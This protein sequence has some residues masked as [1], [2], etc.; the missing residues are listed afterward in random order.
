MHR[1]IL[2][3]GSTSTSTTTDEIRIPQVTTYG[4]DLVEAAHLAESEN[5]GDWYRDP[6]GWPELR[7]AFIET[8]DVADVSISITSSGLDWSIEPHFHSFEVPKSFVGQ[9]PA[10][11][12]DPMS[13]LTY[14][15]AALRAAKQL[16]NELPE[17]S[18]GW[19]FRSGTIVKNTSEWQKYRD[20]QADLRDASYSGET[21]ITSFFASINV[22]RLIDLLIKRGVSGLPL[23]II[24][25]VLHRHDGMAYR[26]GLPQRSSASALLAQLSFSTIDTAVQE[27]LLQGKIAVARR[28]MDDIGFEGSYE[29]V[30][31]LILRIQAEAR[32]GGLEINA[33]K[34]SI[35]TGADKADRFDREAQRLI[36]IEEHEYEND[37]YPG[38]SFTV[39]SR[40]ELLESQ[41]RVVEQPT[42]ASRTEI[43][44]VLRS[45]RHHQE[46]A[47]VERWMQ[48]AKYIPHGADHLSRYLR[49]AGDRAAI[50]ST[51]LNDWFASE[52]D[53]KWPYA[54]WVAAQHAIAIAGD[55]MS[56]SSLQVLKAWVDD[57]NNVQ[58]LAVAV[59]RLT[60][61][62]PRRARE[63]LMRRIDKTHDP[64][65]LRLL[66]FGLLSAGAEV[67][68]VRPHVERSPHLSL[69]KKYLEDRKWTVSSVVDDFAG[70][71]A[72]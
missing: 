30:Y 72:D 21:D 38:M 16:E 3:L 37:D 53:G 66:V 64:L 62:D 10:V 58:K 44:L 35:A 67:A 60:D 18:F 20:S 23:S 51:R 54:E 26:S 13:R 49:S 14:T 57:T 55:R 69:L 28:W 68:L 41:E 42:S 36:E 32:R 6:W 22:Q 25:K 46:F 15:A 12:M 9:R 52:H 34:T 50:A 2:G 47:S 24:E 71:E 19:R 70:T 29:H 43:G 11:L 4:L 33:S 48:I 59:Q 17:W 61:A 5:Y 1:R 27:D 39:I 63:V 8:I 65:L 56:V 45:L 40:D 7:P 31:E